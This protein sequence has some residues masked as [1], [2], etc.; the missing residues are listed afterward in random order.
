M[1]C[2]AITLEEIKIKL[3]GLGR[4]IKFRARDVRSNQD[5]LVAGT[6]GSQYQASV[7]LDNYVNQMLS[8]TQSYFCLL[9]SVEEIEKLQEM[10]F[11]DA[12]SM[13][14]QKYNG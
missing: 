9:S 5:F 4:G 10:S 14:I 2:Q 11:E 7:N 3:T 1:S 12:V 6:G 13:L 8:P